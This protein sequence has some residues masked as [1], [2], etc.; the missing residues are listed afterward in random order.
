[1]KIWLIILLLAIPALAWSEPETPDGKEGEQPDQVIGWEAPTL[2]TEPGEPPINWV[3]N[4]HAYATDQAQA[5]TE[6]MDNFFGDP[7]YDV[8]KPESLIRLQW[9]NDWD[10]QDDYNTKLRLRGKLQ[11][12]RISR[13]LNLVFSGDDGDTLTEDSRQIEDQIG[14]LYNVGERDRSR[15]DLTLG[16]TDIRPG[17]RYRNQGPISGFYSY[18]FTQRLQ[19]EDDEGLFTTSQLNLDHALSER[20]LVR[21]S[22]RA[23]YGEES[24][25][26]EWRTRLSHSQRIKPE[27][28]KHQLVFS[29][30]GTITGVTDP[31]HTKNYRLG[32]QFRRQV[33]RQFLFVELEPAYNWRRRDKEDKREGL[34]SIA[35]RFEIA[36]ERDLRRLRKQRDDGG[37]E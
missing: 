34:W 30:F 3:D 11:L 37:E 6:W 27:R 22:N 5:L 8:E 26:V 32:V 13:R 33:Y 21:W 23:I 31:S 2:A 20:S 18:R 29:Y 14:L 28:K 4:S 19:Y 35:V 1:V 7:N 36:L 10:E 12:P 16:I 15:V 17:I 9:V 25:G 24:D